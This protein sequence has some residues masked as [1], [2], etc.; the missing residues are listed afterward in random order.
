MNFMH[1]DEEV[2]YF[3]S[4]FDPVRHSE[5]YPIPP[6]VLTGCRDKC[7]IEKENNFKQAGERYRTLDPARQDRFIQRVVDALTDPR[8]THE[9]QNIWI[10]Y[11]SQCDTSLG[12]KLASR[13]KL[14]PNM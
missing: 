10:S 9:H 3:P 11:W 13:L 14:K 5:K 1:R 6:R 4:R 7:V 8:V 12:Q 2:N